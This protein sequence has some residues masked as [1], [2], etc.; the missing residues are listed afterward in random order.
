[1]IFEEDEEAKSII[2]LQKGDIILNKS[3]V[4]KNKVTS[5]YKHSKPVNGLT[6]H[7]ERFFGNEPLLGS[8]RRFFK[9]TVNSEY[10]VCYTATVET[11][12]TLTYKYPEIIKYI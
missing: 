6:I 11:L 7:G 1:V 4:N 2:V 12:E 5:D 9:A 10:A 3:G 8:S